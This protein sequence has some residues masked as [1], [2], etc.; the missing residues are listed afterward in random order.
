METL[1]LR[2]L[3]YVASFSSNVHSSM[4]EI[5]GYYVTVTGPLLMI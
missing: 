5:Y 1:S 2:Q 4:L 3:E